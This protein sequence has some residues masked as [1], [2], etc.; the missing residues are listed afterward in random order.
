MMPA[1]SFVKQKRNAKQHSDV[2]ASLS[3]FI[4]RLTAMLLPNTNSAPIE[5]D[6]NEDGKHCVWHGE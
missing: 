3:S 2:G 5:I 6:S 4:R 1:S